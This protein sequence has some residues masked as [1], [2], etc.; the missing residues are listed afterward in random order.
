MALINARQL[1]RVERGGL[2]AG[3]C[4]RDELS[5]CCRRAVDVL[6]GDGWAGLRRRRVVARDRG[7]KTC[8]PGQPR[9]QPAIDTHSLTSLPESAPP[10]H[11]V[12]WGLLLMSLQ[13]LGRPGESE[14]EVSLLMLP[15]TVQHAVL[16]LIHH[17]AL[18]A[19]P[20]YGRAKRPCQTIRPVSLPYTAGLVAMQ[21]GD[22][23]LYRHVM[24]CP[25]RLSILVQLYICQ[26]PHHIMCRLSE[27]DTLWI[28]S[29][30]PISPE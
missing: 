10:P 11:L 19:H 14:S 24:P 22:L 4:G 25:S 9:H 6:G 8:R 2:G 28:P 13:S 23:F 16:C 1:A 27:S 20:Q 15:P 3:C 12:P 26:T 18:R 7:G 5:R 30:R 21:M 29:F 17:H